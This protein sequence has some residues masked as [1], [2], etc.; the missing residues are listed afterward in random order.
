MRV[1]AH[2][3]LGQRAADDFWWQP[4]GSLTGGA[5]IGKA[6]SNPAAEQKQSPQLGARTSSSNAPKVAHPR[7][8]ISIPQFVSFFIN[9][10]LRY[11]HLTDR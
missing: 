4:G 11:W 9:R 3:V 10:V 6:Q 7:H 2:L 8:P 5:E 1:K